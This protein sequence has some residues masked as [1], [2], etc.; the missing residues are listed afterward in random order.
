VATGFIV[1]LGMFF[2]RLWLS[3]A[4]GLVEVAF[5]LFALWNAADRG[6]GVFSPA[7]SGQFETYQLS[8]VLLPTCRDLC[9]DPGNKQHRSRHPPNLR[10]RSEGT[11]VI[12]IAIAVE[13]FEADNR[14]TQVS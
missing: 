13:P 2:L 6:R 3:A 4:Y 9:S 11:V 8:L 14:T 7:F 5:G 10:H 1:A 12:R